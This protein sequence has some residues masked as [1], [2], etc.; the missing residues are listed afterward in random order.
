MNSR[1]V[2]LLN[3]LFRAAADALMSLTAGEP[4]PQGRKSQ[5]WLVARPPCKRYRP[6]LIIVLHTFGSDLKCNP[7]LHVI[8]TG[9]G[10]SLDSR[11]WV[12]A[13]KR[14]LVPAP[15]LGT[16]WKLNVIKGVRAAH[17]SSRVTDMVVG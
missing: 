16:E 7:H 15:L 1:E 11:G 2:Q 5:K 6:G 8:V 17:Q 4:F 12:A 13:P 10:L 3:V 14:Y 9:G